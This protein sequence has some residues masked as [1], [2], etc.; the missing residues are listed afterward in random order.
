[1]TTSASIRLGRPGARAGSAST[2]VSLRGVSKSIDGR[3]VLSEVSVELPRGSFVS[4]MGAN[5]A[6]K[7]T[8]LRVM[9]TLTGATEGEVRIFGES[10]GAAVR[11]KIG[12]VAHETMLYDELTALENV[13]LFARLHG[14]PGAASRARLML[15]QLGVGAVA[16]A[17]VRSMSR[18]V[19]QRVALARAL[20]HGPELLLA[21]EVFAGLDVG[22]RELVE[23]VL[24]EAWGKGCTIVTCG[25]D[26][27]QSLRLSERVLVLERGRLVMD[28]WA[29]RLTAGSLR[30]RL[31]GRA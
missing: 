15:E 9:S 8:L 20:V 4:V 27:E 23:G 16:H 6:G 13:T 18:G 12:M 24:T 2:A 7:S 25:H 19:A 10:R 14:V 29:H 31:G 28:E 11:A 22:S 21:D 26:V 30:E 3:A 17:A 1:M 5:G